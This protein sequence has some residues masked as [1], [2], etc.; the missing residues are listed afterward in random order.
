MKVLCGE[1]KE[2]AKTS[3]RYL[4]VDLDQSLDGKLISETI[5]NKG[6]SR[7]NF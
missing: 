3:V 4:G 7:L 5:L 2:T 6:N 1:T